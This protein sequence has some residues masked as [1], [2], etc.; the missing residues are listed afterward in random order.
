MYVDVKLVKEALLGW[1]YD[2]SDEDLEWAIDNLPAADVV[3]VVYC[4]NCNHS[5]F[6]HSCGKYMCKKGCGATKTEN[7]FC[8]Y[9]ERV[10]NNDK[11]TSNS[12]DR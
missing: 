10:A 8:S 4:K 3:E 11:R 5:D 6:L 12:N 7:D 9:G 1:D 2:P